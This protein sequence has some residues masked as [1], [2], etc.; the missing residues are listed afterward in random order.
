MSHRFCEP[1]YI[2]NEDIQQWSVTAGCFFYTVGVGYTPGIYTDEHAARK[3][4]SGFSNARWK[5]TATY[6][7]AVDQWNIMCERYHEH[8]ATSSVAVS[9]PPSPP[10]P[11]SPVRSPATNRFSGRQGSLS[12]TPVRL[13]PTTHR[14]PV[15]SASRSAAPPI[16][17]ASPSS[18]RSAPKDKNLPP[19]PSRPRS[20]P[21]TTS[22]STIRRQESIRNPGGWRAGDSLWGIAGQP[23]FFE[24]RYDAVDHI[25]TN[26]LSPARLME[27]SDLRRLEAFV[28]MRLD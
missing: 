15:A 12:Q 16:A 1:P 10:L 4:I 13:V 23:I 17:I 9:P 21:H 6:S 8:S 19:G 7:D 2:G 22:A 27:T 11:P 28:E 25:Y 20:G 24:D 26:R 14:S 5:K 18:T 3:Q